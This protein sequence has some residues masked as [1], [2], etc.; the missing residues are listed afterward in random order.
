MLVPQSCLTLCNLVDCSPPGT[1]VYGILQAGTLEWVAVSFSRG[2]SQA[3][4]QTLVSC[5][6][7]SYI[8]LLSEAVPYSDIRHKKTS[9]V[10]SLYHRELT[11]QETVDG[12]HVL[13]WKVQHCLK[14]SPCKPGSI[15]IDNNSKMLL[16]KHHSSK[17]TV[18][19]IVSIISINYWALG[20]DLGTLHTLSCFIY[21]TY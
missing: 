18:M 7:G 21:Y 3:G 5:I 20:H 1:A 4:D 8:A 10:W 15:S 19:I 11:S 16:L 14:P 2:S 9:I 12:V 17:M 6:A 13:M